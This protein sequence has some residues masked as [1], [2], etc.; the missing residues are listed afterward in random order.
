MSNVDIGDKVDCTID[1]ERKTISFATETDFGEVVIR[2]NAK[3][4]AAVVQQWH[5]ADTPELKLLAI[6]SALEIDPE[7]MPLSAAHFNAIGVAIAQQLGWHLQLKAQF[8]KLTE[9]CDREAGI[10]LDVVE[11][12]VKLLEEINNA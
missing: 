2:L 9:M 11:A 4:V 8:E 6:M 5:G 3:D 10:E 12:S 7:V 1:H